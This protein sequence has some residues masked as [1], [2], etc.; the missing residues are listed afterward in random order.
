MAA[1]DTDEELLRVVVPHLQ[2]GA[3]AGDP[4]FVSLPAREARLVRDALGDRDGVTFLPP[5]SSRGRPPA[6]IATLIEQVSRLTALGAEQVRAVNTVPHPGL[7]VPWEGWRLY[8]AAVNDLLAEVPVW[9]LCLYDGR[10]TPPEVLDDAAR[11][12]PR[13]ATPAGEHLRNHRYEDP[14]TFLESLPAG[15]GHPLEAGPPAVDLLDPLPREARHAVGD[16]GHRAGLD[17][18][19]VED[20][21]MATSEAVTNAAVHGQPPVT[22]RAWASGPHMVVVVQDQGPGPDDPYVGLRPQASAIQG[23]G[24]FGLW[25]AHQLVDVTSHHGPQGFTVR[26]SSG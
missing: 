8:E 6:A 22:L 25:L 5:L 18:D 1:Y 15:P 12:H 10:I 4:T 23:S 11:A 2:D 20:L 17:D 13:L 26:L 3:A 16:L 19:C 14:T 7:G 21:V 24:G 9:G